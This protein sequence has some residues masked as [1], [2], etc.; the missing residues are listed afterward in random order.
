M[1]LYTTV[2]LE[3]LLIIS[4]ILFLFKF[5][6]RLGLAPLYILLGSVQYLQT[7]SGTMVSFKIFG[8]LTIYPGSIIVFSAVL[9][10]VLLIYIK[11]GVTSARTLIIGIIISNFIL[12]GLFGI[13]Y[14]Q[15]LATQNSNDVP[16]S[17]VFLIDYKY[18]IT[19]TLILLVDFILLVI[20]YQSLIIKI[21]KLYFFLVLFISLFSVLIFD[22]F[23]FN[24]IL[25]SGAL[26][27]KTSLISHLIG[28]SISALVFSVILYIYLKFIDDAKNK[29]TFIADQSRDIFSILTNRKKHEN[30]IEQKLVSQ[31]ESTLHNISDG[32]VSLDTNWCYTYINKKAAEFLNRSPESLIG[33]HIWTEFPE[34]VGLPIYKTYHKAIETQKTIYFEDYYEPLDKWFENRVYPSADGLTIYFTDITEQKKAGLAVKESENQIK[35]ILETEPECIKQLNQKGEL[36][37]MNPAGLAMIEADSLEMVKGESVINII[38]AEYKKDFKK[39]I[40]DVFNGQTRKLIFEITGMK[41]THRWLETH[42]VPFKDI[43]G[44]IISL[45]GVTRDITER[46]KA[47][48]DLINSELLFRRLTSNA[49]VG[50]FQTDKEGSANF[51]NEEWL[52][53]AGM[54]FDEALGFGWSN[55]IHPDDKERVVKAWQ[56]YVGTGGELVIEFRLQDKKNNIKWVSVKAVETFDANNKLY[57]YIGIT[58]DVSERKEAEE[59]IKRSEK[60]LENIINNIGDPVFVKDDQSRLMLVNNAFCQL[61]NLSKEDAIGKTLAENVPFEEREDFL[62]VD[63]QVISTGVENIN[64]ETLT[65]PGNETKII[66]T[67]KT[68]FINSEG[69]KFLIGIIRDITKRKKAEKEILQL[70]NRNTRII[71]TLLDGFILADTTGKILDVNPSYV[72]MTGYSKDELLTMNINQ[73]EVALNQTEIEERI[74]EMVNKGFA[75]FNSNHQKKN[76]EII[77]LDVNTFAMQ[78]NEQHVVAAFVKDI[79]EH[80]KAE[81][82]LEKHRNNLEELVKIRTEEVDSK[83]AELQRMNKLFVG[84]ELRMKEL[85]NIIKKLQLKDDK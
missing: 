53:Y 77:D 64:E 33:K 36:L 5:R 66:T 61:F 22:A 14:V 78:V 62:K 48:E 52:N 46:K 39:Q 43:E 11:E 50:I 59:Q 35:T 41:G 55:A 79:T 13:T 26:D 4:S 24:I 81:I 12:S 31:L 68:R 84:R 3:F 67:R 74:K 63:K 57:G 69:N 23:A 16:S 73:L 32:F 75:R 1:N 27:F 71:E 58:L 18:F 15:E 19:G 60:Y 7:L 49:P 65:L 34:G 28:K 37:Y 47:E 85:K 70:G 72:N 21:S 38:K 6:K 10:A 56:Q 9:F 42:A 29:A 40:E 76:G 45:L 2:L 30:Q 82:E 25:K 20:I 83:N 17:S 54:S 80:N 8:E 51:L 44:N